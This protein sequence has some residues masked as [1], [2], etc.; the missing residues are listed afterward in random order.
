MS[1]QS[2]GSQSS[3]FP[4]SLGES[5]GPAE[6]SS[7]MPGNICGVNM[8]LPSNSVLALELTHAVLPTNMSMAGASAGDV[9]Y[10]GAG[11]PQMALPA[12]LPAHY[13]R[14]QGQYGSMVWNPSIPGTQ[15]TMGILPAMLGHLQGHGMQ[16]APPQGHV[17]LAVYPLGH[18][19]QAAPPQGHGTPAVYPP[20][21]GMQATYA[22]MSMLFDLENRIMAHVNLCFS[23]VQ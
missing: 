1:S 16:A 4:F 11:T 2:G 8:N 19:M 6:L 21:H 3:E 20:G 22:D 13:G 15:P 14:M 23:E 5:N 18:G 12:H 9:E 17:M 10:R 7:G